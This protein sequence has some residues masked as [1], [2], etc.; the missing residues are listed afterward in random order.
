VLSRV[1]A[2]PGQSLPVVVAVDGRSGSGKSTLARALATELGGVVVEGDDFYRDMPKAER[3]A[4]DAAEGYLRYFDWER[5]RAAALEPLLAGRPARYRPFDWPAGGGL[6]ET[7]CE[8][9]PGGVIVVDGVYSGRPE[10]ADL[11]GL[12]VLVDV[13][14]EERQR[15]LSARGHGND[16]WH[17]RWEA[18][19]DHYFLRVRPAQSFDYVVAG[20]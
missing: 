11:V 17:S 8:V 16:S 9:H 6:A 15:R 5:L 7:E 18:A 1:R 13:A 14:D 20:G 19:E 2:L 10:L 12:T 3:W 4:L